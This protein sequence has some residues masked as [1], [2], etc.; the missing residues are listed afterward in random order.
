[1]SK[2]FIRVKV[3]SVPHGAVWLQLSP[4]IGDAGAGCLG[5]HEYE[6]RTHG[7]AIHFQ[8]TCKELNVEFSVRDLSQ[9]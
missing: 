6:F 4:I 3:L 8:E 5:G 2:T 9:D 1:M 7:D